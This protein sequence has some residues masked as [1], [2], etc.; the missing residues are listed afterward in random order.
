MKNNSTEI[1]DV[2]LV[3]ANTDANYSDASY[4]TLCICMEEGYILRAGIKMQ[5]YLTFI[6]ASE[7]DKLHFSFA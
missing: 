4:K 7:Q 5:L 3:P 1:N 6:S 2:K